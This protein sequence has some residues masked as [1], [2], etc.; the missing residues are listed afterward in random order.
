[1]KKKFNDT[2]LC[3]LE[4]HDMAVTYYFAFCFGNSEDACP[5]QRKGR[6]R[7]LTGLKPVGRTPERRQAQS[8]PNPHPFSLTV[9]ES[10]VFL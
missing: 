3:I 4:K 5:K 6:A 8:S 10:D 7:L 9:T 1:M 2:G